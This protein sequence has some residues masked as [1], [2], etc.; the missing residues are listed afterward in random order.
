MTGG[1]TWSRKHQSNWYPDRNGPHAKLAIRWR[2]RV[3]AKITFPLDSD[4][5]DERDSDEDIN[6]EEDSDQEGGNGEN[7]EE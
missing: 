1:I 3:I 4:E 7:E 6:E 2:M 5:E